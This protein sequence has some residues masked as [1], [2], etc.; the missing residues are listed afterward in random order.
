MSSVFDFLRSD[1]FGVD[2]LKRHIKIPHAESATVGGYNPKH[3]PAITA[4]YE[5]VPAH[6]FRELYLVKSSQC[7]ASLHALLLLVHQR[8]HGKKGNSIVVSDSQKNSK[9][10]GRRFEAML[11][12]SF[13]DYTNYRKRN[14]KAQET[15]TFSDGMAWFLGAGNAGQLA[16]R[17]API[18]I[19][20]EVDK[21]PKLLL[22]AN[23]LAL[24]AQRMKTHKDGVLYGFSTPTSTQGQIWE[25]YQAAT[26]KGS[27]FLPCP[28]CGQHFDSYKALDLDRLQIRCTECSLTITEAQRVKA[29]QSPII[30]LIDGQE[31]PTKGMSLGL[32]YSD[33]AN[34]S[35]DLDYQ[36]ERLRKTDNPATKREIL[37]N[38]FAI[39]YDAEVD[40]AIKATQLISRQDHKETGTQ[41]KILLGVDVQA[42]CFKFVQVQLLI[43]DVHFD[44]KI[45]NRGEVSEIRELDP[46]V[47][48]S[49]A[50]LIDDG[51]RRTWEVRQNITRF[52]GRLILS[53]GSGRSPKGGQLY[54]N[55]KVNIRK[56]GLT[57]TT[58]L[59][60][61]LDEVLKEY[62]YNMMDAGRI[63]L[64]KFVSDREFMAELAS[65]RRQLIRSRHGRLSDPW[66][67]RGKNDYGDALKLCCLLKMISDDHEKKQVDK[68]PNK[69]QL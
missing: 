38:T 42:D 43:D 8:T 31:R 30:Q 4:I 14:D 35:V 49:A 55:S 52:N 56:D 11:T 21:H 37:Q 34:P 54:W 29:A 61:F 20:D 69:V 18:C 6:K 32:T 59:I 68:T 67:A 62:T 57:G 47:L 5:F 33:V 12:A 26:H 60:H 58:L 23:T 45:L 44:M 27:V 41:G 10:L 19:A 2:W 48:Q 15:K 50:C 65:E 13:P 63:N 7:G 25:A 39:P 53:K 51:G 9:D 66:V 16:S 64:Q 24:L 22:E 3:N 17:Q 46:Y 28:H 36:L 40:I 1:R